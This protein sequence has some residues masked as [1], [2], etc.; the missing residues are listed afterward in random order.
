MGDVYYLR[1][2]P[3][4]ISKPEAFHD[5]PVFRTPPSPL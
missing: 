2:A 1:H 3:N 5:C 4:P